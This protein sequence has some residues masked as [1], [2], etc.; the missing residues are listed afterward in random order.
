MDHV[1]EQK[2]LSHG[3]N[4]RERERERERERKRE[5]EF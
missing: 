5:R 1:A 4:M 3:Q 2:W